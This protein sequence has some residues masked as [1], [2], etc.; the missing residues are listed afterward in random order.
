LPRNIRWIEFAVSA[1]SPLA[2]INANENAK[3]YNNVAWD[4]GEGSSE[5]KVRNKTE[6]EERR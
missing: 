5:L 4:E 1:S 6:R 3:Q 2:L